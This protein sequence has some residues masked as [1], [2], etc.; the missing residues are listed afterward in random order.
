MT[1]LRA[2]P[3]SRN[4]ACPCG[5]GRR[6]KDCHGALGRS[7]TAPAAAD[8]QQAVLA[9]ALAAQRDGRLDAAQCGYEEILAR[10]PAHF[11]ALHMLGVV[12][13]QRHEI[14]RGRELIARACALRPDMTDARRN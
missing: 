5:S 3:E 11:D 12:H 10:E 13:L 8:A 6:Y 1:E 14:E 7:A 4:A 9:A 2:A